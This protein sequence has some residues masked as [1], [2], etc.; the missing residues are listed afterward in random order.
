MRLTAARLTVACHAS[1]S[2][3]KHALHRCIHFLPEMDLPVLWPKYAIELEQMQHGRW[4]TGRPKSPDATSALY[5]NPK[6]TFA[7]ELHAEGG[8]SMRQHLISSGTVLPPLF[9]GG[10]HPGDDSDTAS[11]L[12]HHASQPSRLSLGSCH[13]APALSLRQV[14]AGTDGCRC[15]LYDGGT[16]RLSCEPPHS[17]QLPAEAGGLPPEARDR[18]LHSRIHQPGGAAH[19]VHGYGTTKSEFPSGGACSLALPPL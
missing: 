16:T 6:R 11:K 3:E 15:S 7:E 12:L 5:A 1:R 8:A 10:T 19:R 9:L 13:V 2:T 18:M 17:G 4:R 14:G